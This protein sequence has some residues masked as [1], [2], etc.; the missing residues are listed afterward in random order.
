MGSQKAKVK[1]QRAK[2]EEKRSKSGNKSKTKTQGPRSSPDAP[3]STLHAPQATPPPWVAERTLGAGAAAFEWRVA[4]E[5]AVEVRRRT[6][7]VTFG[8]QELERLQELV[9]DGAWHPAT[10]ETEAALAGR[11]G[12]SIESLGREELEWRHNKRYLSAHLGAVLANAGVWGWN[13][14]LRGVMFRQVERSLEG[15]RRYYG[16]RCDGRPAPPADKPRETMRRNYFKGPRLDLAAA[17]RAVSKTMRARV[18]ECDAAGRHPIEKGVRRESAVREFLRD[19]LTGR[20]GVDRGEVICAIG[21]AS[22]Q[23]DVLVYDTCPGAVL[24]RSDTS[25]LVAAESVYAA[26]EIKPVLDGRALKVAAENIASVKRLPRS[27]IARGLPPWGDEPMSNP[28]PFGAVFAFE[29]QPPAKLLATLEKINA[30]Q[31]P[32]LWVDAVCI[33]DRALIHRRGELPGPAGWSPDLADKPTLLACLD[34]GPDSLLLFYHL[35]CR[36][37][38]AKTLRPPDL[39]MY[40]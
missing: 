17:F 1:R 16:E 5:G 22:R 33:L 40:G 36:D 20:Y 3:H 18:E 19:R 27:A 28:L 6:R 30:K 12:R 26:I 4:E 8:G 15:V 9:G 29:S 31:P 38:N 21:E 7:S 10:R 39:M 37:L 25:V 13:G 11:S 35:L 23:V 24:L 34:A 2:G 14:Q 32:A